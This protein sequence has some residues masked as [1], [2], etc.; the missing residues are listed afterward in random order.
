MAEKALLQEYGAH[1]D[2]VAERIAEEKR[3]TTVRQRW[4]QL[5]AL[6]RLAIGLGLYKKIRRSEVVEVRERWIKLKAGSKWINRPYRP[7]DLDDIRAMVV[8][9][10]NL[11]WQRIQFWVEQFA[12]VLE[13]PE[14][15]TDIADLRDRLQPGQRRKGK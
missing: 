14:L 7:K 9:Q 2:E 5:N 4:R 8:S 1:G 10:P 13:M 3:N 11:D 15:W 6:I 12:E